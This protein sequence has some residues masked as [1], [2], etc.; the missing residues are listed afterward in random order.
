MVAAVSSPTYEFDRQEADGTIR[1]YARWVA[2]GYTT[3]FT[4]QFGNRLAE[5]IPTGVALV[6]I[7]RV[8]HTT[9]AANE[10]SYLQISSANDSVGIM[11]S[12]DTRDVETFYG[13]FLLPKTSYSISSGNT[14]FRLLDTFTEWSGNC[15][16][17]V[18]INGRVIPEHSPTTSP[19]LVSEPQPVDVRKMSVWP[20]ER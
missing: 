4:G 11:E 8:D 9:T 7:I 17:I 2:N 13:P 14:F 16:T 20:W 18:F 10:R 5:L 6:D 15:N 19:S 3:S 12:A 1:W